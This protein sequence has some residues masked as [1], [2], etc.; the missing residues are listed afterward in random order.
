MKSILVLDVKQCGEVQFIIQ[1]S[2]E[3]SIQGS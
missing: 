2:K 1:I 3:F